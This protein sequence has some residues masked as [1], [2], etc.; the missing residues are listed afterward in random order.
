MSFSFREG[1]LGEGDTLQHLQ[2]P[3]QLRVPV[4]HVPRG[5]DALLVAECADDVAER[6][7]PLVDVDPLLR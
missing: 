5:L 7:E 3:G 6:Q 4:R 2:E 1:G